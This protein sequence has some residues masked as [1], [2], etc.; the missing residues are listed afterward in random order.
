MKRFMLLAVTV[1]AVGGLQASKGYRTETS[2]SP[3][4]TF[5]S[6]MEAAGITGKVLAGGAA[7]AVATGL[8]LNLYRTSTHDCTATTTAIITA[9]KTVGLFGLINTSANGFIFGL[10]DYF[11]GHKARGAAFAAILVSLGLLGEFANIQAESFLS[12]CS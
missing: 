12:T 2:K 1:F 5:G 8:A 6:E 10:A 9:L 3:L 7:L 11:N 4:Y